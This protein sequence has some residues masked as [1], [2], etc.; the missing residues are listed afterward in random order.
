MRQVILSKRAST[1]LEKLLKYLEAEWSEK[2]KNNFIEKLDKSIIQIQRFPEIAPRTYFVE[3]L[4]K[5]F[6][7]K[8]TSIFYRRYKNNYYDFRQPNESKKVKGGDK[9]NYNINSAS[10][11][12]SIIQIIQKYHVRLRICK[13][14]SC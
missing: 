8:Q 5:Y 3:G 11:K 4:Y 13:C 14:H 7:T 6:V 1:R 9:I 10:K 12:N 2:V